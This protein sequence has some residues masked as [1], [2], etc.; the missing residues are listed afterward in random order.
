[1]KC[2]YCRDTGHFKENC[3]QLQRRLAKETA[4]MQGI[5]RDLGKWQLTLTESP[6]NGKEI[7]GLPLPGLDQR[8]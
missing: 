1:M 5:S 3:K 7:K 2:W 8:S 6:V 4:A